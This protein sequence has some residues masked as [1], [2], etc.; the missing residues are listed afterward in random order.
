M[1]LTTPETIERLQATLH[2]KAKSRPAFRFYSLY[3]KIYREDV[4]LFAYRTAKS[5]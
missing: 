5:N 4:L 2:A 1:G 3:D